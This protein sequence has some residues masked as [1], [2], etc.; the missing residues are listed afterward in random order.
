[1]NE[2]GWP[3]GIGQ[4]A[5]ILFKTREIKLLIK[6]IIAIERAVVEEFDHI[7]QRDTQ[8]AIAAIIT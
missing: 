5:N 1:M 2:N 4:K 3:I 7:W 8:T 6:E